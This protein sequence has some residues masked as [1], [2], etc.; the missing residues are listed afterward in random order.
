MK[1]E[2]PNVSLRIP[3]ASLTTDNAVMIALAGFY[4]ASRK[5]F[6]ASDSLKANGNL[7]LA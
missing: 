2:Y 5:E 1:T 7:S 3:H 4:R 6:A